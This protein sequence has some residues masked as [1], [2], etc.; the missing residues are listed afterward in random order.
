MNDTISRQAAIQAAECIVDHHAI[1]PYQTMR[2]AMDHLQRILR[3]IP[4]A[5][6]D[7]ADINVGD[8]I[9][10]QAAINSLKMD[11]SIIPYAKAREYVSAAL[12]TV[13]NRL[14]QLPSA[15]PE[16]TEQDVR[17]A[18]N[19]GYRCGMEAAQPERKTG[20]W[21]VYYECPKCGEITKDFTEY[22]PFCNADMR[23][24][25]GGNDC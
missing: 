3:G 4:S 19:D 15:Q 9:Y 23:G 11:I 18:F 22:C 21:I 25:Q 24:E 7:V 10:R 20:R 13:F 1:T 5:Q 2:S 16:Y 17:D 14:E 12:E 6:P 8:T